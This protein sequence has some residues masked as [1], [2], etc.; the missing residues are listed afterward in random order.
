MFVRHRFIFANRVAH[1]QVLLQSRV[2]WLAACVFRQQI[3]NIWLSVIRMV[4]ILSSALNNS[5]GLMKNN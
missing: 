4:N 3:C 2:C 5:A 1:R